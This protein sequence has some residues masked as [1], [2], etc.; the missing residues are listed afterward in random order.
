MKDKNIYTVDYFIEKFNKIPEGL[1]SEFLHRDE[2]PRQCAIGHCKL[3]GENRALGIDL[4][5]EVLKTGVGTV[6]HKRHPNYQQPTPK[7]R[8][9]AALRDI[10]QMQAPQEPKQEKEYI[11]CFSEKHE[12]IE[13]LLEKEIQLS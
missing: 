11:Y 13:P 1:W 12:S 2:S 10:K 7:Q 6:I 9:L 8:I 3:D 4:F 5:W